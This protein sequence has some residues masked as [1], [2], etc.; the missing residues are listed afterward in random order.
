MKRRREERTHG[1]KKEVPLIEMASEKEREE[2]R[3]EYEENY[4]GPRAR[5]ATRYSRAT[6]SNIISSA[7]RAASTAYPGS[8]RIITHKMAHYYHYY[9]IFPPELRNHRKAKSPPKLI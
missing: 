6:A 7:D 9:F 3:V 2:E 8:Y 4:V 5:A 1:R